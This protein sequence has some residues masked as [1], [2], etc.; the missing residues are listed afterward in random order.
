MN[1]ATTS[2]DDGE[3]LRIIPLCEECFEERVNFVKEH[4]AV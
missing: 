1:E 4:E 3:T 2:I